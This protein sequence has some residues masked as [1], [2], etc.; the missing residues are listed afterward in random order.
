LR[1]L[2]NEKGI[3]KFDGLVVAT[4]LL[5][6]P[7]QLAGPH[8]ELPQVAVCEPQVLRLDPVQGFNQPA[9][10]LTLVLGA[11]VVPDLR[12][13]QY[14]LKGSFKLEVLQCGHEIVSL[15]SHILRNKKEV[16]H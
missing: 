2:P 15:D 13:Q 6:Q 1:S 14:L 5:Q 3:A 8:F 11:R 7:T 10:A 4:I 12:L 16:L 9:A